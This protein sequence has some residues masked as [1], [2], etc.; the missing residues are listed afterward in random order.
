[1]NQIDRYAL[2]VLI[3]RFVH[4]LSSINGFLHPLASLLIVTTTT[5]VIATAIMVSAS[6]VHI[7]LFCGAAAAFII[8]FIMVHARIIHLAIKLFSRVKDLSLQIEGLAK[9]GTRD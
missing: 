3:T 8:A 7:G 5:V 9:F 1:M 6:A 2:G 4:G